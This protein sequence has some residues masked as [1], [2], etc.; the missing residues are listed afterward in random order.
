MVAQPRRMKLLSSG[1]IWR[2]LKI[3]LLFSLPAYAFIRTTPSC[4]VSISVSI[5]ANAL[6]SDQ[7]RHHFDQDANTA[8]DTSSTVSLSPST[9]ST[10]ASTPSCTTAIPGKYGSVPITA[11]NSYYNAPPQFAA[12]VALAVLFGLLTVAHIAEAILFRK[13]SQTNQQDA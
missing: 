2:K 7:P 5:V 3:A 8:M 10:S 1:R 9:T 12:A 4:L 6:S 11:C 13:V